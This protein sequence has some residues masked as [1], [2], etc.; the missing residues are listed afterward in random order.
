[1]SSLK[2]TKSQK[3]RANT[4]KLPIL[5]LITDIQDNKINKNKNK[6]EAKPK[7]LLT[8]YKCKSQFPK[9]RETEK[10]QAQTKI[11]SGGNEGRERYKLLERER[12]C[13]F[14]I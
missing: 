2:L 10:A 5:Q 13:M 11:Q 8:A 4:V 7:S 14:F 3:L 6:N 9:Q 1:M 12:L